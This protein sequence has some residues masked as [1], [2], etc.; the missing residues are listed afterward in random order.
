[1]SFYIAD[2]YSGI[3]KPEY[4]ADM[5]KIWSA[6][7]WSV[8]EN[9]TLS[10][11]VS[12]GLREDTAFIDKCEFLED[13]PANSYDKATRTLCYGMS[14]NQHGE[15]GIRIF[16]MFDYILPVITEQVISYCGWNEDMDEANPNLVQ[17]FQRDMQEGNKILKEQG[18]EHFLDHMW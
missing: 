15:R 8:A 3:V 11:I 9:E 12:K 6:R 17:H 16:N 18:I 7:D 14:G 4:A 2:W 5:E 1:M 10:A 13:F